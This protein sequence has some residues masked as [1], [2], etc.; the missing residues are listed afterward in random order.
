M[1]S[2]ENSRFTVPQASV[3]DFWPTGVCTQRAEVGIGRKLPG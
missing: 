3:T 1:P 2:K